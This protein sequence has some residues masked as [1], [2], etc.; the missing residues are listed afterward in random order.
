[1]IW[2]DCLPVMIMRNHIVDHHRFQAYDLTAT[3]RYQEDL[4]ERLRSPD[5]MGPG[6][7]SYPLDERNV[8]FLYLRL[9]E[10]YYDHFVDHDQ[11]LPDLLENVFLSLD[12]WFFRFGIRIE[13]IYDADGTDSVDTFT[14]ASPRSVLEFPEVADFSD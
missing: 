7:G 4:V 10:L 9:S 5:Y 6:M 3:I 1:M 8:C 11:M 2:A 13:N 14:V 12:D